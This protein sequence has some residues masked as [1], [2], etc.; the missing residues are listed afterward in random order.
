MLNSAEPLAQTL[1]SSA[2]AEKSDMVGW[3]RGRM[4]GRAA[5]EA[6][7]RREEDDGE[8]HAGG[9]GLGAARGA[10]ERRRRRS[11]GPRSF[12]LHLLR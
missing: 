8:G 10:A 9:G 11:D 5:E 12:S 7:T 1:F 4:D 6:V 2:I 3:L